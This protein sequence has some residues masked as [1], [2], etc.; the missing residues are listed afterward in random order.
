[1]TSEGFEEPNESS[2]E[3]PNLAW[4]ESNLLSIG[5]GFCHYQDSPHVFSN[6]EDT[7]G[8]G[9]RSYWSLLALQ[10]LMEFVATAEEEK[11]DENGNVLHSFHPELWPDRVLQIPSTAVKELRDIK[12]A[13]HKEGKLRAMH[14]AR[15]FLPCHYFDYICGSST[16]A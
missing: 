7:D 10:K 2:V 16:G 6:T 14:R 13:R 5:I 15:R 11:H 8:G 4:A 12:N 3:D 1:M 9:I